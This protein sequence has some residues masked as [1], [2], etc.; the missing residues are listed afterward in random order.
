MDNINEELSAALTKSK[1]ETNISKENQQRDYESWLMKILI[2]F[3]S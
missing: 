1:I 2:W 3:L